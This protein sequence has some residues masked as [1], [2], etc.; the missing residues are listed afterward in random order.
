MAKKKLYVLKINPNYR[1]LIPPLSSDE[2]NLLEKSILEKGCG[3]PIVVW[4]GTIIDGH[5]RYLICKEH[6]I[7]FRIKKLYF[8]MEE[9]AI[10]WICNNKLGKR[11][12][13]IETKKYLIGKRYT[14]EKV[15]GATNKSGVNQYKGN[16]ASKPKEADQ[17]KSGGNKCAHMLGKQYNLSHTS[18]YNYAAYAHYIDKIASINATVSECIL[19]GILKASHNNLAELAKLPASDLA[20]IGDFL[21]NNALNVAFFNYGDVLDMLKRKKAEIKKETSTGKRETY[22]P[23]I[24]EVAE[25]KKL[26]K[27]DP[28]S[29]ITSLTLTIPSWNSS[30]SRAINNSNFKEVSKKA[31]N[32]LKKELFDLNTSI[33]HMLKIIEEAED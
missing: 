3:Q 27:Y 16:N 28:D 7:P 1:D 26:P 33:I 13:N 25:I 14:A 8:D 18:I 9:E 31:K 30:I 15:I 22:P 2:Y 21:V 32:R 29:E 17:P 20:V 6:N 10:S 5:H 11:N 4:N 23:P 12:L 19:L 24:I